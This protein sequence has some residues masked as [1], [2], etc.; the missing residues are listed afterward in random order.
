MCILNEK[1]DMTNENFVVSIDYHNNSG[2]LK[3][4]VSCH[5]WNSETTS[6]HCHNFYEFFIVT[7]GEATHELNNECKKLHKGTLRLIQPTD[8]HKIFS[9]GP[10][11]CTHINICVTT[12]KLESICNA[13]GIS[14]KE[15]IE[16]TQGE[17]NLSVSEL[18]YF[19][20][21]AQ[22]VSLMQFDNDDNCNVIICEMIVEIICILYKKI[23]EAH[24]DYPE[25]F[26]ETL[27]IIHSPRFSACSADDVYAIA[28][29]SPP[30]V[31]ENFKKYTG[32]TV[33]EYLRDI[34]LNKACELLTNSKMPI[35]DISNLF[36]YASL[37][38]FNK[39]FKEHTGITPS[40][41]RKQ[42]KE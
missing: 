25:W 14:T 21:K 37:S 30:V 9:S 2:M 17:I 32:K 6:H 39:V 27:D 29:F 8:S 34:K 42:N 24:P 20:K 41:Y 22:R 35:V 7:S 28:G 19:I 13:L 26:L 15:L 40:A 10:K 18:E 23:K 16:N 12:Q 5:W 33:V 4:G 1:Q 11:S 36:G 3:H 31:I 38:H